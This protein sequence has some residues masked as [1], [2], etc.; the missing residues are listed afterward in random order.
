M[1][2]KTLDDQF[3]VTLDGHSKRFDL[4]PSGIEECLLWVL[5][6]EEAKRSAMAEEHKQELEI[7][8]EEFILYD[9]EIKDLQRLLREQDYERTNY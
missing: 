3:E 5:M 1:R 6:E 8:E 4:T 2:F 7:L 9:Q